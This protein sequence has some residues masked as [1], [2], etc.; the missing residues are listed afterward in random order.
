MNLMRKV[1]SVSINSILQGEKQAK[2]LIF[3]RGKKSPPPGNFY[4]SSPQPE[5]KCPIFFFF[6]LKIVKH[7]NNLSR[8]VSNFSSSEIFRT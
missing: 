6:T 5:N 3:S 8:E 1:I 2:P 7:W 4:L